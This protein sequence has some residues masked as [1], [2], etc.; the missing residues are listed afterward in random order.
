MAGARGHTPRPPPASLLAS[1]TPW[2][3]HAAPWTLSHSPVSLPPSL[4]PSAP[5]PSSDRAELVAADAATAA[6]AILKPHR[7]PRK[8]RP[9]P[10]FLPTEPSPSGSSASP[11]RH[12]L[13]PRPPPMVAVDSSP[14]ELPRTRRGHHCTPREL[15]IILPLSILS[16]AC[17]SR[18]ASLTRQHAVARARRRRGSGGHLVPCVPPLGS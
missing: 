8:L 4:S 17:R 16:L 13:R 1:A 14:S 10:L 18:R 5:S 2:R 6:A 7:R 11:P 3:R 12:R 15:L 9:D